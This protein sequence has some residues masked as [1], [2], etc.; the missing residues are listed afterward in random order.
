MPTS[1]GT[2]GSSRRPR[3]NTHSMWHRVLQVMR[4]LPRLD[5]FEGFPGGGEGVQG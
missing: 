1:K 4:L 5:A 3:G 2:S